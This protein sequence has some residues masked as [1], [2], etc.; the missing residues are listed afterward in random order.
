MIK[1]IT[2]KWLKEKEACVSARRDWHN[3]QKHGTLETLKRLMVKNPDWANWLIVRVMSRKQYLRYAIYAALQVIKIYED[4]YPNDNRPREAIRAAKKCIK[5]PNKKNR[6]ASEAASEASE[7]ASRA[8]SRA[9]S[10]AASRAASWAAGVAMQKKI[11]KYGIKL[12]NK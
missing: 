6:A 10:W 9:A 11:L 3:E 4:K 12:L 2:Q 7:A 1:I 5:N 8:A